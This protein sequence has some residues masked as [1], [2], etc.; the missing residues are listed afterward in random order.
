MGKK[1]GQNQTLSMF[2]IKTPLTS[3]T[4]A[5]TLASLLIS[6][7]WSMQYCMCSFSFDLYSS[8]K[9]SQANYMPR[10]I[11]E[12]FSIAIKNRIDQTEVPKFFIQAVWLS[13]CSLS[14]T[15]SPVEIFLN[16]FQESHRNLPPSRINCNNTVSCTANTKTKKI[17]L[18]SSILRHA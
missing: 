10:K 11:T 14:T 16:S 6:S 2:S 3:D 7:G 17:K 12:I 9:Q 15:V 1:R 13:S 5:F 4:W 8:P 18:S